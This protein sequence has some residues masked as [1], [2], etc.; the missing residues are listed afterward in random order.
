VD[1]WDTENPHTHVV[2]RGKDDLG[3]DLIIVRAYLTEGMRLRAGELSTEAGQLHQGVLGRFAGEAVAVGLRFPCHSTTQQNM[4]E[5]T[6]YLEAAATGD[7]TANRELFELIYADLKRI[8]HG[9]LWRDGGV[10]E[11][12]TT[13]LVHES[14][15]KFVQ[16][17]ALTAMDRPAFIVYVGRVMRSVVVDYIRERQAEKRGGGA[18]FI[19]LTTSAGGESLDSDR[20]LAVNVAMGSLEK[21]APDL[22]QLVEM[23]YFAG[24][25]INEIAE[26]KGVSSRTVEREWEKARAFLR[27]LMDES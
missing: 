22:H 10:A 21:I 3:K 15:L 9:R 27:K 7:S 12:N 6:S 24:L 4:G 8:A 2:L 14:Y 25:S 26:L 23:R 11:L 16:S 19:T 13:M 5:V 18:D 1:H 17:G 20:L